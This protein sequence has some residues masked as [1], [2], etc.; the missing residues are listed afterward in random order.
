MSLWVLLHVGSQTGCNAPPPFGRVQ[1]T[2][3]GRETVF[4]LSGH[5]QRI[6]L[7]MEVSS[8]PHSW[9]GCWC[10]KVSLFGFHLGLSLNLLLPTERLPA[11]VWGAASGEP[12]PWTTGAAQQVSLL[13]SAQ[14][15]FITSD[16]LH[17]TSLIPDTFLTLVPPLQC[18]MVGHVE[19]SWG[20][21]ALSLWLSERLCWTSFGQPGWTR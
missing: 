9:S 15:W 8:A 12:V 20:P 17:E 2:D 11:P 5:D 21:A 6:H 16:F 10:D 18:V 19:H 13:R 1:C 14:S 4:L 3:G 7:Y